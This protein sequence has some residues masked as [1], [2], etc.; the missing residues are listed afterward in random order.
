[1]HIDIVCQSP[2]MKKVI[3][4]VGS[5]DDSSTGTKPPES[6]LIDVSMQV[7]IMHIDM[8]IV[9]FEC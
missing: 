6:H 8:K 4:P 7:N 5:C 3:T 9:H 2:S 1:M